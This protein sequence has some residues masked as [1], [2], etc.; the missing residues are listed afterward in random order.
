MVSEEGRPNLSTNLPLDLGIFW[1]CQAGLRTAKLFLVVRDGWHQ[2]EV[3]LTIIIVFPVRC[4]GQRD[5]Q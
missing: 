1:I 4:N 5:A 2:L 3:I